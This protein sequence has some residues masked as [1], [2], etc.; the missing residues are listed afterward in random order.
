M[1]PSRYPTFPNFQ[2][3]PEYTN[4]GDMSGPSG[5]WPG[6][7]PAPG[8]PPMAWDF[9]PQGQLGP[10]QREPISKEKWDQIKSVIYEIYIIESQ[11]LKRLEEVMKTRFLFQA[12]DKMYRSQFKRWKP[13]FDKNETKN[14]GGAIPNEPRRA[15]R[16]RQKVTR[17]GTVSDEER[18]AYIVKIL[19]YQ[20][21]L[22]GS[23]AWCETISAFGRAGMQ[24]RFNYALQQVFN[25]FGRA[26]V[27]KDPG[28]LVYFWRIAF[29]LRDI[30]LRGAQ[31]KKKNEFP[32]LGMFLRY[33]SLAFQRRSRDHPFLEFAAW[34]D[35]SF[36]T[37]PRDF[38]DVMRWVYSHVI[39]CFKEMMGNNHPIILSMVSHQAGIWQRKIDYRP[40]SIRTQYE[41]LRSRLVQAYEH[42]G[43]EAYSRSGDHR[44]SILLDYLLAMMVGNL[45]ENRQQ[46]K[47]LA[48]ELRD[49]T[50][51]HCKLFAMLDLKFD[52]Q[53]R[54]FT[55]STDWL[56]N[57]MMEDGKRELA[58][59]HL[60]EA[61]DIL[62]KGDVEC[63]MWAG[64]FSRRLGLWL[65]LRRNL[66]SDN[67]NQKSQ[68]GLIVEGDKGKRT[69]R[70][71]SQVE[72]ERKTIRDKAYREEKLRYREIKLKI[73][74]GPLIASEPKGPRRGK[75]RIK[76]I[77]ER[78]LEEQKALIDCVSKN[79]VGVIGAAVQSRQLLGDTSEI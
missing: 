47:E 60:N 41:T 55:V 42:T 21:F 56:A 13:A 24:T 17:G 10:M 53:T 51:T 28:F 64:V 46:I 68:R 27:D 37:S 65:K 22:D 8:A 50:V 38:K 23:P 34:L 52:I 49:C 63:R 72:K 29:T 75:E 1:D 78:T 9:D 45:K 54:A 61:I 16:K 57:H 79:T 18:M 6:Y 73:P 15:P 33:L 44:V 59:N 70:E 43:E 5:A 40:S 7:Y 74:E 48:I 19:V 11:P 2:H 62:W 32:F 76:R 71:E 36:A 20:V 39:V 4:A 26:A 69:H 3:Q 30:R 31:R 66:K 77:R 14:N 67:E 35:A 25:D 58:F 12:S